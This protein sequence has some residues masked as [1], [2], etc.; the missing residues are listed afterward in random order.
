MSFWDLIIEGASGT[1]DH[2]KRRKSLLTK[3]VKN[4]FFPFYYSPIPNAKFFEEHELP[5]RPCY[6]HVCYPQDDAPYYIWEERFQFDKCCQHNDHDIV[7]G[8][9]IV[10]NDDKACTKDVVRCQMP[11]GSDNPLE[12]VIEVCT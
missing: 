3:I 7:Y 11:Q 4:E 1:T 2:A 9:E 8:T 10:I 5:E 12:A 6:K